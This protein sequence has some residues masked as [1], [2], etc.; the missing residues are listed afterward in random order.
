MNVLSLFSGIGGLDIALEKHGCTTVAYSDVNEYSNKIM[1]RHFPEAE[2]LG[3]ITKLRYEVNENGT[4]YIEQ[5][6]T[7][8]GFWLPPIDIICG[9][10]PCQDISAAWNGPGITGKRSGLWSNYADAI[11]HLRPGGVLVE[12]VAS[13]T[14]RGLGTVLGD[15]ARLGYDAEWAVLRASQFGAPHERKRMFL[16]AYPN[17][18]GR[19]E[20]RRPL[21]TTAQQLTAQRYGQILA[22]RPPTDA[23]VETRA[24]SGT[25][26][27]AW[28]FEP[29]VGRVAHGIPARVDRLRALGN[30]VVPQVA[31]HVAGILIE[32][33][34]ES[35]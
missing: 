15:L 26:T 22:D 34:K 30:A 3:D 28:S 31:E 16:L 25:I 33:L 17:S 21:T 14:K 7:G 5:S 13:I 24:G 8:E 4:T 20:Q 23:T 10:F 1:A 12:N 2:S 27:T 19:E 32:R 18:A 29:G 6:D 35:A 11:R 9:G